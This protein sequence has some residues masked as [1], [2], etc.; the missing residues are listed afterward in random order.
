MGGDVCWLAEEHQDNSKVEKTDMS[1]QHK[2]LP[3]KCESHGVQRGGHVDSEYYFREGWV[4]V[5][6]PCASCWCP[7]PATVPLPAPRDAELPGQGMCLPPTILLTVTPSLV[8]N[9]VRLAVVFRSVIRTH[10]EFLRQVSVHWDFLC[11]FLCASEVWA[12]SHSTVPLWSRDLVVL[13]V[14]H[15]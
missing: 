9:M 14:A 10:R 15:K 1:W 7:T 6:G 4:S 2:A 13:A 12:A 11:H 8:T 3:V 5:L